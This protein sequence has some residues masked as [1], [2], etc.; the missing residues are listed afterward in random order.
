[1]HASEIFEEKNIQFFVFDE[2]LP[3]IDRYNLDTESDFMSNDQ[4]PLAYSDLHGLTNIDCRNKDLVQIDL[5]SPKSMRQKD[6]ALRSDFNMTFSQVHEKY[7]M[8]NKKHEVN[9]T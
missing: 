2:S 9:Q 5:Q 4:M 7:T 8:E 3:N 1:M 6:M